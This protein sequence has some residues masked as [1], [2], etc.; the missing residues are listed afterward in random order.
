[1]RQFWVETFASDIHMFLGGLNIDA[2]CNDQGWT[3][4]HMAVEHYAI[5]AAPYLFENRADPNSKDTSGLTPLHLA[6]DIETDSAS[7][8]PPV[9]DVRDC[10]R[11][12]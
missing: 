3:A 9:G 5:D 4:L 1:M 8:K 10:K 6:V 12:G 2:P 11:G 7:P